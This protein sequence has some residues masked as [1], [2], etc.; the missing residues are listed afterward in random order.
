MTNT[1]PYVPISYNANGVTKEFDFS[2]GI[3]NENDIVVTLEDG[4]GNQTTLTKGTDYTV[5]FIE[6]S[7][8]GSITTVLTYD[9]PY[10]IIVSRNRGYNQPVSLTTSQGFRTEDVE[11]LIADS[12]SMQIQQLNEALNRSL[13]KRIGQTGEITIPVESEGKA[14]KWDSVGNLVNSENDPDKVVSEAEKYAEQAAISA[15]IAQAASGSIPTMEGNAGKYLKV[16][17]SEDG[18]HY[19]YIEAEVDALIEASTPDVP[20]TIISHTNASGVESIETTDDIWKLNAGAL[21]GSKISSGTKI[22]CR[23]G[24]VDKVY[25]F[26]EDIDLGTLSA[27][28]TSYVVLEVNSGSESK[29]EL[30]NADVTVHLLSNPMC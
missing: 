22:T 18:W 23:K 6:G 15:S 8:G 17:E 14:L 16:N 19:E 25:T 21:T 27:N 30:A 2:W 9:V 24:G 20:Q 4:D 13:K 26:S 3:I 5:S 11:R 28:T 12:L 7:D 10:K 1:V 29:S